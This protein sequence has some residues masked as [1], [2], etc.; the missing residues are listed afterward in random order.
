MHIPISKTNAIFEPILAKFV[1]VKV[2]GLLQI[3]VEA[4][5]TPGGVPGLDRMTADQWMD[6]QDNQGYFA[7]GAYQ[8]IPQTFM[9]AVKRQRTSWQHCYDSSSSRQSGY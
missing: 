6:L 9:N 5:D 1:V 8:F 2:L 4:G 7:L 3:E